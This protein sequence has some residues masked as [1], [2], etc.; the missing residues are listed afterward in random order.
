MLG[1]TI[2]EI[3]D[4][5][6]A[7]EPG[8][9]EDAPVVSDIPTLVLSGDFDP[10]TPPRW[11]AAVADRLLDSH[12]FVFGFTGHG[13]M[14]SHECAAAMVDEFVTDPGTEP[15]GSCVEALDAPDYSATTQSVDMVR[16]TDSAQRWTGL[17][18]SGW[19]EAAPG[20]FQ[21]SVFEG[22]LQV[23]IKDATADEMLRQVSTLLGT[24]E[25]PDR[26]LMPPRSHPERPSP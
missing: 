14:G 21:D 7:G 24:G 11:G 10:V 25:P 6:Q 13:V 23:V 16:H 18:P 1:P 3:C 8:P 26:R 22:L 19:I 12:S 4:R 5:W 15:D 17:R 20:M 9:S 2:V